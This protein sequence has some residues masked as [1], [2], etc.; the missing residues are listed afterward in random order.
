MTDDAGRQPGD[1]ADKAGITGVPESVTETEAREGLV[2]LDEERQ[3]GRAG[4]RYEELLEKRHESG[5]SDEEANELGR[6]LAEREGKE[7]STNSRLTR[8]EA[9]ATG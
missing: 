3:G 9:P 8:G 2:S 5:L 6:M 7:Y 1:P 4:G